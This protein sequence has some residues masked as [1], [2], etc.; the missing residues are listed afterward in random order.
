[1]TYSEYVQKSIKYCSQ[2]KRRI[3]IFNKLYIFPRIKFYFE[4]E[5]TGA[6]IECKPGH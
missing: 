3:E 1:M 4:R 2:F 5:K 6:T